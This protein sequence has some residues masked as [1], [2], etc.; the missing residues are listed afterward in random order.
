MLQ[1]VLFVI[2]FREKLSIYY[3]RL[4]NKRQDKLKIKIFF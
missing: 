3:T 2:V 1:D 4:C